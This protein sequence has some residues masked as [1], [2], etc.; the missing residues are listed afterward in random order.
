[1]FL[2]QSFVDLGSYV[3]LL[4]RTLSC[5]KKWCSDCY[6]G[7][8]QVLFLY[9]SR[10]CVLVSVEMDAKGFE[11]V[12]LL[13]ADS[14][15]QLLASMVLIG[16]SL[17]VRPISRSFARRSGIQ[18]QSIN[19]TPSLGSSNT[20]GNPSQLSC[21]S[22]VPDGRSDVDEPVAPAYE[23]ATSSHDEGLRDR[24]KVTEA[25]QSGRIGEPV[26]VRV[27]V[28]RSLTGATIADLKAVD[29]ES[30]KNHI[31]YITGVPPYQQALQVEGREYPLWDTEV[32]ADVS[33]DVRAQ[34]DESLA[35]NITM[36]VDSEEHARRLLH[37]DRTRRRALGRVCQTTHSLLGFDG[38]WISQHL[39]DFCRFCWNEV[40]ISGTQGLNAFGRPCEFH[41]N[42]GRVYTIDMMVPGNYD[43]RLE[44]H[45]E[46]LCA[47]SKAR[48]V[49]E[50]YSRMPTRRL[51]RITTPSRMP[52]AEPDLRCHAA[53]T[54]PQQ[55]PHHRSRAATV[56]RR[57]TERSQMADDDDRGTE[58]DDNSH[59]T[60]ELC[61]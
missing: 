24:E 16:L 27:H 49:I 8:C 36:V 26:E 59:G 12:L 52:Y 17:S 22:V 14:G 15:F 53:D 20:M 5:F 61:F 42:R 37:L 1:M 9:L 48:R 28:L 50:T 60:L 23:S 32:L 2:L 40:A 45:G 19:S 58:P 21:V 7:L 6:F 41:G 57:A 46:H 25:E 55:P 29:V 33:A 34:S 44:M 4:R 39:D 38:R 35:M 13:Y 18:V 30:L 51:E 31:S 10:F 47:I 54:P 43:R 11:R 3:Y 56:V